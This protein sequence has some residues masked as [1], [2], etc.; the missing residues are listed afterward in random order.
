MHLYTFK[1]PLKVI[2]MFHVNG[3]TQGLRGEME[4]GLVTN[5]GTPLHSETKTNVYIYLKSA[6][7]NQMFYHSFKEI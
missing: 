1:P 5:V 6:F 7:K 3:C 2:V 4:P